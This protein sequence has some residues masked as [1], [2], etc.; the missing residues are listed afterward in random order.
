MQKRSWRYE[1]KRKIRSGIY[2][3][4]YYYI[5]GNGPFLFRIRIS[6]MVMYSSLLVHCRLLYLTF[7]S[8]GLLQA[9][10]PQKT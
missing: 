10:M 5:K 4:V 8:D 1:F 7:S 9:V 3:T 6:C 2:L